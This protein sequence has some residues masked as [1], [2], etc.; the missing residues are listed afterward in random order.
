MASCVII[1]NLLIIDS[2]VLLIRAKIF[3]LGKQI[4]TLRNYTLTLVADKHG[5]NA[6]VI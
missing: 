6:F 1:N 4:A 2:N 5:V 3:K